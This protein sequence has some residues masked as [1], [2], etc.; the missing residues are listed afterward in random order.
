MAHYA[1][2]C[3][4][5][6]GHLL[7]DGP[8]GVELMRRGHRVT[9]VSGSRA[10]GIAG[11]LGLPL[12][13]LNTDGIHQPLSVPMWLAFSL[14]GSGWMVALRNW[15]RWRAEVALR[16]LPP[17][18]DELQPDGVVIDHTIVAAG[19]VAERLG[20]PFVTVCSG[21]MWHEE[22][23]VPPSYTHLPYAEDRRALRRNRWAYAAWHWFMR[24]TLAD[25]NRHRRAWHL[26]PFR[27]PNDS[28]SPLAQVSQLC[29]E[30]DFP[31][32]ELPDVFH[33]IG[34][35]ASNRE[36]LNDPAFP[37]D[38]LDGRPL[39]FVSLGSMVNAAELSVLRTILAACTGLDAQIVFSLGKWN[40]QKASLRERI[41]PAPENVLLVDFAPQLALLEKAR[42]LITHAGL[43]TVLEAICRAV[44]MVAIPKRGDTPGIGSRI[45]RSGVG[46]R[47]SSHPTAVQVRQLIDRVLTED[48]FRQRAAAVGEAIRA[49]G[50][51]SRAAEIVE[52][53]L[54]TGRPVRGRRDVKEPP[55]DA[56][57]T[58]TPQSAGVPTTT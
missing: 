7:S 24:P 25:I 15:F 8:L 19:S 52:K 14:A 40:D 39:V 48:S 10:V 1:L 33:Y 43:N 12:F 11:Q 9:M 5:D 36:V 58:S 31:R 28:M 50:G 34:S 53:A 41:G 55:C 30:F 57:L 56:S 16:L 3:P 13:E 37:W 42:L 29:P 45:E 49:A 46:L 23:A 54:T 6:A 17:A 26:S 32:R 44:P 35:L 2:I 4:D 18:L 27:N 51:A 22:A 20:L 21:T 47:T 38:W